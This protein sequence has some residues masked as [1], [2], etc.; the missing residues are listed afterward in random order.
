MTTRRQVSTDDADLL[1]DDDVLYETRQ[2]TSVRRYQQPTQAPTHTE[3]RVTRHQGVPPRASQ[4]QQQ[5]YA[6]QR[7]AH[8]P[9]RRVHWLTLVGIGGCVTIMLYLVAILVIIPRW[10]KMQDDAHYG[11]PRTY[12]C[13][14]DVG[15]GGVS[16]F[17]VQNLHGHVFVLELP[18]ENPSKIT[19]TP[20]PVL[21]GAGADLE[22][23]TVT[24]QDVNGDRL[25][26]MLLK[27]GT[28]Q[29]V[30]LNTGHGFRPA[31]ANDHVRI[32]GVQP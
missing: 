13:D 10:D 25:P 6:P 3:I 19:V 18:G 21:T 32:E 24:F 27:I 2:H 31:N 12:Q 23:A 14:A 29:Y 16:H 26:D 4:N 11:Y 17:I 30:Y 7:Q 1:P 15:H 9:R 22:P 20:G 28:S 8:P 5:Q